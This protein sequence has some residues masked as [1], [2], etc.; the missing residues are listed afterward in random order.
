MALLSPQWDFLYREDNIFILNQ[1]TDSE[2]PKDAPY[3][4]HMMSYGGLLCYNATQRY[5]FVIRFVSSLVMISS[6]DVKLF[7]RQTYIWVSM[8][9]YMHVPCSC[10]YTVHT[11]TNR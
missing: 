5:K 1:G 3:L 7:F 8:H 2:V 4:S 9:A 10:V 11:H 6:V